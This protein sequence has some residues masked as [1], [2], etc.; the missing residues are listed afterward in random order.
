MKYLPLIIITF[1]MA[2]TACS[3]K[4]DEPINNVFAF[5]SSDS[6]ISITNNG[7]NAVVNVGARHCEINIQLSG[8]FINTV[9]SQNSDWVSASIS[10]KV[11]TLNIKPNSQDALRSDVISIYANDQSEIILANLVV[12][13]S[14]PT[15]ED[16]DIWQT[17]DVNWVVSQYGYINEI[18]TSEIEMNVWY[19]LTE[20]GSAF[21]RLVHRDS[22]ERINQGDTVYPNLA[23]CSLYD[24]LSGSSYWW[25]NAIYRNSDNYQPLIVSSS[26]DNSII[27]T[28]GLG[29]L[30]TLKAPLCYGD[31]VDI[32][33]TSSYGI[34]QL[35]DSHN[36]YVYVVQFYKTPG[37]KSD[38]S[39]NSKS[40]TCSRRSDTAVRL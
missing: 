24:M 35:F 5:S 1:L 22:T 20:D 16:F 7:T 39:V 28:W 18:P 32:I 4:D 6:D 14:A 10:D 19:K 37:D 9:I 34:P 15:T 26:Y 8:T 25:Q 38:A 29:I 12:N 33:M 11:M 27:D 21:F 2:L 17:E 40:N 36:A 30:E 13:Q 3:D 23:V 31:D